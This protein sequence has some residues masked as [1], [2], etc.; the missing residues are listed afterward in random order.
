MYAQYESALA[1]LDSTPP[2]RARTSASASASA[3]PPSDQRSASLRRELLSTRYALAVAATHYRT[4]QR[5]QQL[6]PDAS[7]AQVKSAIPAWIMPEDAVYAYGARHTDATTRPFD[8]LIIADAHLLDVSA[9]GLLAQAQTVVLFGDPHLVGV[10]DGLL[11]RSDVLSDAVERFHTEHLEGKVAF[12]AS[13]A[14]RCSLYDMVASAL[15]T[16]AHT[17]LTLSTRPAELLTYANT[18]A[19]HGQIQATRAASARATSA[20]EASARDQSACMVSYRVPDTAREENAVTALIHACMESGAYDG[21]TFGIVSLGD[22]AYTTRLRETLR[23]HFDP[24][25]YTDQQLLCGPAH[26]FQ[27]QTRDV[28]ILSCGQDARAVRRRS[29]RSSLAL[30]ELATATCSATEQLWVVHAFDPRRN[31]A[32]DDVRVPLFRML[33]ANLSAS[34]S[35]LPASI[36]ARVTQILEPRTSASHEGQ[37]SAGVSMEDI[38]DSLGDMLL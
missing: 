35:A 22:G 6:G 38:A 2:A 23:A 5:F 11:A 17:R 26:M 31:L 12:S 19:Y 14:S 15:G 27:S 8:V 7:R 4:L 28:L 21:K 37:H 34:P 3:R 1:A 10:R 30:R 33:S 9:L 36:R 25:T 24:A 16:G 18:Q 32:F 13:C 20:R 29:V